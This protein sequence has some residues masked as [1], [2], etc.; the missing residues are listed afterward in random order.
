MK[1]TKEN[2]SKRIYI[3]PTFERILLDNEIA[4]A[5]E[6]SPPFGP[7]ES[8]NNVTPEYFYSDPYAT[9]RV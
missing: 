2:A 7:D 6:S 3:Q 5:L 9:N 8:N 1:N 4:L